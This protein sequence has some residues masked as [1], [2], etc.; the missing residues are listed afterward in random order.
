MIREKVNG[1]RTGGKRIN[2]IEALIVSRGQ[3]MG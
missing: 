2:V 3:E 1:K